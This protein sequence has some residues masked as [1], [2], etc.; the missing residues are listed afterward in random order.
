M[1][2]TLRSRIIQT[3]VNEYETDNL[4]SF[5]VPMSVRTNLVGHEP[6]SY[7]GP[8]PDRTDVG[9]DPAEAELP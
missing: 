9:T 8:E 5:P 1:P 7:H 3:I 2:S 6:A 4:T